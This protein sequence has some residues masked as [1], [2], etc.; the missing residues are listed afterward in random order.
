[1]G[2]KGKGFVAIPFEQS[3]P[4]STLGNDVVVAAD[5]LGADFAR[6]FYG[7]SIDSAWG[8]AGHTA[9]EGSI[10]VGFAHNDLS[11]AEI[12]EN[13]VA[14]ITDP[15]DIIARERARRP[16]RKVGKFIGQEV[17]EQLFDG[18]MRRTKLKFPIGEGHGLAMWAVN[19]SG[20]AFSTG[21]NMI[22]EGVLYG[23]WS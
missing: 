1:M 4:L 20:A 7:I 10:S 23:R 17:A 5:I 16:V 15:S 13:L 6:D 19:R 11:V 12:A 22:V 2:R 3:L 8:M 18:V 9:A 14:E 21:T